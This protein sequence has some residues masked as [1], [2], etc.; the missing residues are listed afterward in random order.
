M[1]QTQSSQGDALD[2]SA[3]RARQGRRG[4]PIFWVLAI[5]LVLA[6]IGLGLAW[7]WRA[8]DLAASEANN[9]KRPALA[10]TFHSASSQPVQG[11]APSQGGQPAP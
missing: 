3:T 5:S 10:Q 9:A 1:A 6:A 11:P 8:P 2:I 4:G 7:I